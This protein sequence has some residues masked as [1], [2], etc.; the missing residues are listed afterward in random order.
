M[1]AVKYVDYYDIKYICLLMIRRLIIFLMEEIC[2]VNKKISRKV[3]F[4]NYT[5]YKVEGVTFLLS[6]YYTLLTH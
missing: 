1:L 4:Q 2:E 5:T 3:G 6:T